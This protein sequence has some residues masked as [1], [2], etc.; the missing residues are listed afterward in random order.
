MDNLLAL[1]EK[2]INGDCNHDEIIRL[3]YLLRIMDIETVQKTFDQ[4]W[5]LHYNDSA[6]AT[7]HYAFREEEKA[8]VLRKIFKE[9]T[10]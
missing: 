10:K 9:N 8:R 4:V 6:D 3:D 1:F 7:S 5:R 2:Y